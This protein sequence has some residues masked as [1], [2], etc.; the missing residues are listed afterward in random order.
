M[1]VI[2]AAPSNI[3]VKHTKTRFGNFSIFVSQIVKMASRHEAKFSG[4]LRVHTTG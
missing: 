1:A 4:I 2:K 3:D